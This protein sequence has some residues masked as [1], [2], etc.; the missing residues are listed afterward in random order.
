[1]P[2][3]AGLH[4]VG[5]TFPAE[6]LKTEVAGGGRAASWRSPGR[7]RASHYRPGLRTLSMDFRLDGARA[8]ARSAGQAA[9]PIR[10]P[11]YRGT[12]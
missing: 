7:R 1:M 10:Q 11:V 5:V 3:K 6:S 2:M 9:H 12:L 8:E 4:T